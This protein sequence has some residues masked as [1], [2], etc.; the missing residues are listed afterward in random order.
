MLCCSGLDLMA[1]APDAFT[2]AHD[3]V[4]NAAS[5]LFLTSHDGS[6][7]ASFHEDCPDD[8]Q[9][10]C[11]SDGSLFEGPAE[12]SLQRLI[13]SHGTP[14]LGQLW[15]P[16][17]EYFSSNTYQLLVRG[18]GHHYTIDARLEANGQRIGIISL[19]REA[20][21][22][23]D[24]Q[25]LTDLGR[26]AQYFEHAAKT[27]ISSLPE[28]DSGT[29]PHAMVVANTR[30]EVVFSSLAANALLNEIPLTGSQWPD[31]R[32]LPV[33]CLRLI[34]ILKNNERFAWQMP[35]CTLPMIGGVLDVHAQWMLPPGD[36]L[37]DAPLAIADR[38]LV[39]ITFI[40]RT[41]LPL[42]VWRNLSTATLSPRQMEV[43]FW[44]AMGGGREAARA[45]LSIS[46]AVLRDCVKAVY[47]KLG[48]S[49]ESDLM[50]TLRKSQNA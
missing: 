44:M 30:G 43:A 37:A 34:E 17:K 21:L 9:A 46:E 4:P 25:N 19:F 50:A 24:E 33:V 14:K 49:S 13:T 26:I 3:L 40:R 39:G 35:S 45:R 8:V 2:I 41:P 23:F 48:C 1:I 36:L 6:Q 31:R 5:A 47:E 12:P 15:N 22:G 18:C 16:P 29:E 7:Q 27:S 42:L 20:G 38:G 10:L 28:A 11:M 32:K